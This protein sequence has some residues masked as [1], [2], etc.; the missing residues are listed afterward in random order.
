VGTPQLLRLCPECT[1]K[2]E[3]ILEAV[4]AG[5]IALH[6]APGTLASWWYSGDAYAWIMI[7]GEIRE[8]FEI[9][10]ALIRERE[11]Q[12]LRG[13]TD[14]PSFPRLCEA[15]GEP[16]RIVPHTQELDSIMARLE[17]LGVVKS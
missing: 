5:T 17:Q 12:R 11:K 14:R 7:R 16:W 8:L 4:M 9:A 3:Q 2:P 6:Q 13:L 15:R 10:D 1:N